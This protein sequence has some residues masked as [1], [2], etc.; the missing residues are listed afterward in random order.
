M[1]TAALPPMAAGA[2]APAEGAS[3][4]VDEQQAVAVIASIVDQL[5]AAATRDPATVKTIITT[6]MEDPEIR[7]MM[8]EALAGAP[9]ED[10]TDMDDEPTDDDFEA[11]IA[12]S[13][14]VGELSDEDLALLSAE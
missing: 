1:S 8:K 11:L 6:A 14:D 9:S 4:E 10:D 7:A 5:I 12:G 13:D 3:P 2:G